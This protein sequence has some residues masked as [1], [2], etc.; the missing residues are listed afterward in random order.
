MRIFSNFSECTY[1]HVVL[2]CGGGGSP[3][4]GAGA[5]DGVRLHP[6]PPVQLCVKAALV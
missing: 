1:L 3:M 6:P 4:G 2:P 5:D